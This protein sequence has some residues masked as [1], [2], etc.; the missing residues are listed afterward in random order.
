[1]ANKLVV[2]VVFA[3]VVQATLASV[4]LKAAEQKTLESW[5]QAIGIIY[6]T[7][8]NPWTLNCSEPEYVSVR[9]EGSKAYFDAANATESQRDQNAGHSKNV[10]NFV[11]E[12][13]AVAAKANLENLTETKTAIDNLLEQVPVED[14]VK[15]YFT[16][17]KSSAPQ[18]G[19]VTTL[20]EVFYQ[21]SVGIK[22]LAAYKAGITKSIDTCSKAAA[23]AAVSKFLDIVYG[24]LSNKK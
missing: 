5:T 6:N 11:F 24:L 10:T 18:T 17:A 7:I 14:N 3:A 9:S 19:A 23:I 1:M 8:A 21:F 22:S 16:L 12:A 20:K 13:I 15:V 4:D 2:F